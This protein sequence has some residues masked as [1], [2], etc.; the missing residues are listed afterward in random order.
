MNNYNMSNPTIANIKRAIVSAETA[1]LISETAGTSLSKIN[2]VALKTLVNVA[3]AKL[4][5]NIIVDHYDKDNKND[6]V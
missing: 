1:L 3:K 4:L 6:N 5:A 2:Y